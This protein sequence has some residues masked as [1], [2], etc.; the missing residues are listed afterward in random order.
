M[1][2][3]GKPDHFRKLI[4]HK[5]SIEEAEAAFETQASGRAFKVLI[6]P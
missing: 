1:F 3:A 4:T 2:F 6:K 5:F